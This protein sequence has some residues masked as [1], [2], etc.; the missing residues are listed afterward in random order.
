[1]ATRIIAIVVALLLSAACADNP[2]APPVRFVPYWHKPIPG[3]DT[4]SV[5]TERGISM[6]RVLTDLRNAA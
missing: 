2:V 6:D 1:M 5:R 3:A 4:I